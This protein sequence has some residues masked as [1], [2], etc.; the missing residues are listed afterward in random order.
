MFSV[1]SGA[2][3]MHCP[4]H[5][6]KLCATMTC[7][8]CVM[9]VKAPKTLLVWPSDRELAKHAGCSGDPAQGEGGKEAVAVAAA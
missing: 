3:P 7:L 1:K 9:S 5:P 4:L 8:H 2:D 6:G